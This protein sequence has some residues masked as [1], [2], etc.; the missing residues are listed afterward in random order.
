MGRRGKRI[1]SERDDRSKTDEGAPCK[2]SSL[3]QHVV[4]PVSIFI[5]ITSRISNRHL[6]LVLFA[7]R[8]SRATFRF[9]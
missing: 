5:L 2:L 1:K 8:H 3:E 9:D 6:F 4:L 7:L